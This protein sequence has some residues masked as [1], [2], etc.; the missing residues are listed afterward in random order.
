MQRLKVPLDR[1]KHVLHCRETVPE[2]LTAGHGRVWS[3]LFSEPVDSD[4]ELVQLIGVAAANDG[5]QQTAL[6]FK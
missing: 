4:P 1:R 3:R 5:Q 6:L 2:P